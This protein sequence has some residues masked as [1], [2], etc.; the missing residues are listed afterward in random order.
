[1]NI[2]FSMIIIFTLIAAT[3]TSLWVIRKYGNKWLGILVGF[4]INAVFLVI[5]TVILLKIDIQTFHK[6]TDGL[7]GSLG[8]LVLI[9]FI[10]VNTFINY[11]IHGFLSRPER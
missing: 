6:E 5:A 1:M 8:I 4:C 3:I 2:L 9:F 10:P 11:Y 7:F